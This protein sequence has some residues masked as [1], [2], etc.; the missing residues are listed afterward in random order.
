MLVL[1][2]FL[3]ILTFAG[4]IVTISRID[5]IRNTVDK[6]GVRLNSL[7]SDLGC[8]NSGI[9]DLGEAINDRCIV[10]ESYDPDTSM[11]ETQLLGVDKKSSEITKLQEEHDKFKDYREGVEDELERAAEELYE[12]E[13]NLDEKEEE[14]EDLEDDLEIKEEELNEREEELDEREKALSDEEIRMAALRDELYDKGDTSL[15]TDP[16]HLEA[17]MKPYPEED[18]VERSEPES[19]PEPEPKPELPKESEES[20]T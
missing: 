18:E 17:F 1:L 2:L 13:D 11:F 7:E 20:N 19:E 15:E 8:V 9:K 5:G 4:V 16:A 6:N 10:V 12:I 3:V 14:L